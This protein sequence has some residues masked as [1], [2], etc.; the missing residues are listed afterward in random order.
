MAKKIIVG[1][2]KNRKAP[3]IEL[4]AEPIVKNKVGG[5][6]CDAFATM[7]AYSFGDRYDPESHSE[8][9]GMRKILIFGTD[10]G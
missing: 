7:A 8:D 2:K 10:K 3:Q 6:T 1:D 4:K 5:C 9:C